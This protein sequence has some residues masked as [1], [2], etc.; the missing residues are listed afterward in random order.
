MYRLAVP[1]AVVRTVCDLA[2]G[3]APSLYRSGRFAL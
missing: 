3:A 2:A 1:P